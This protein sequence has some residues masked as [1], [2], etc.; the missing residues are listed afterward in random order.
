MANA[1]QVIVKGETILDLRSDTVTPE[2]L[3]KGYTAHDKSG[4]KI[5]GALE[6]SSSGGA[7]ETWVLNSTADPS[8]SVKFNVDFTSNGLSF[9]SITLS[10]NL[11]VQISYDSTIVKKFGDWASEAYRKLTFDTPPPGELLTW[12]QANGVKQPDDTAVQDT[13]ALTITS[14]GTVSVT[15]DAPYDALKKVDVT[16]NV[17]SGVGGGETTQLRVETAADNVG[18]A[19][20]CLWQTSNGWTGTGAF[21]SQ[22]NFTIPNVIVGGYVIITQEPTSTL[23]FSTYIYDGMENIGVGA[24]DAEDDIPEAALVMKVT[25]PSPKITL[26]LRS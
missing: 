4:T 18:T 24:M 23:Q 20:F 5:T 13:K 6:A 17:A 12:L 21:D 2:T 9:S 15:P 8:G 25:A 19:L 7:K 1:N 3:Q 10:E 26:F 14:N 11:R 22:T 16:V